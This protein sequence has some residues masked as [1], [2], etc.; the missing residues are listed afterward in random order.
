MPR[1]GEKGRRT[2]GRPKG[3]PNKR[4]IPAAAETLIRAREMRKSPGFKAWARS[5]ER[6]A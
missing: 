6:R 4:T 3:V 5:G 2:G 1:K